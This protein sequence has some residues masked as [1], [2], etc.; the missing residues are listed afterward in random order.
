VKRNPV[1]I[2]V[3]FVFLS[4]FNSVANAEESDPLSKNN[5][6]LTD[7]EQLNVDWAQKL[8]LGGYVVHF[9]HAQRE[10]WN[11]VFA[12]DAYELSQG[13]DASKSSFSRATCLTDQGKQEAILL[14]KVFKLTNVNFSKVISS[15]SC[16]AR[17]TSMLAFMK[18]DRISNSLL[19]RSAIAKVQHAEFDLQLR[20]LLLGLEPKPG[21]NIALV[22]HIDTLVYAG[23]TVLDKDE[24]SNVDVELRD[25]TGFVILEKV[26]K[27]IYPR[28]VFK[29]MK[30][31]TLAALKLP[32]TSP[33]LK[34]VKIK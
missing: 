33:K 19:H 8:R 20:N 3:V 17:Q 13:L 30:D 22:G 5:Y 27:K 18:I 29:S 14:G 16:R 10:Q 25:P 34:E 11:D 24:S 21:E 28:Y 26:G 7:I 9:R 23:N 15:P 1:L 6:Q 12:F 32:L 2:L 4:C 31:F